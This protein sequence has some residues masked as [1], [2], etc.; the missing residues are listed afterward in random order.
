MRQARVPDCRI[1]Q[2]ERLDER[3]VPEKNQ[4]LIGCRGIGEG[5]DDY[6]AVPDA[7][8]AESFD[9]LPGGLRLSLA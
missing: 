3:K 9:A 6:I 8:S 1:T 4:V 2:V 5:H 7:A